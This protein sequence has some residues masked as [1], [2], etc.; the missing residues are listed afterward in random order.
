MH[1]I[2]TD[3]PR[4]SFAAE[5]TLKMLVA[6]IFCTVLMRGPI[7]VLG[8]L[9]PEIEAQYAADAADF[10]ILT[11]IPVAC[12]GVFSF[13]AFAVSSRFGLLR[14]NEIA[15]ALL[16][17]GCFGRLISH[18]G[19]LVTATVLIGAGI[20]LLNVF[21]PVIAKRNWPKHASLLL[22]LYSG[23]VGVSGSIGSLCARPTMF[24]AGNLWGSFAFWFVLACIGW[25]FWHF[26]AYGK[27]SLPTTDV[28]HHSVSI[29]KIVFDPLAWA[30]MLVMGVQ[31]LL[32]YTVAAWLPAWLF[33]RG[34]SPQAG[35]VQLFAYLLIG[36]LGSLLTPKV[37]QAIRKDALSCFLFTLMYMAG[38]FC[39]WLG[40]HWLLLGS[41]L[42]GFAQ[43][44]ML[45]VALLFMAQKSCS[46]DQMLA[47][48]AFAQGLGYIGAGFGPLLFGLLREWTQ[49]WSA[50]L[51]F[52]VFMMAVWAAAG[53]WAS[54]RP[55]LSEP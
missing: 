55:R 32:I 20:A 12:F 7:T 34:L 29:G 1:S 40:G 44:A 31:S 4:N 43:G 11:A 38:A 53:F 9:A 3:F 13:A 6:F 54:L 5:T 51:A 10:G 42:A 47:I 33:D 48:S 23:L 14:A 2:K 45:T 19:A 39:W 30:L 22:G 36:F 25:A 49:A 28:A 52:T 27:T 16:V 15:I 21:M 46:Q 35:A 41:L 17:F 37:L 24:W 18:W 8:P 26:L 50:S